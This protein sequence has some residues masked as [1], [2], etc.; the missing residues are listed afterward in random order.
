[1]NE[2]KEVQKHALFEKRVAVIKGQDGMNAGLYFKK[3]ESFVFASI[4]LGIIFHVSISIVECYGLWMNFTRSELSS[5]F[6]VSAWSSCDDPSMMK[7][8]RH[9]TVMDCRQVLGRTGYFRWECCQIRYKFE[10]SEPYRYELGS[11]KWSIDYIVLFLPIVAGGGFIVCW[12]CLTK[13]FGS[14]AFVS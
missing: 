8:A 11:T 7:A 14:R 3:M 4:V 5:A 2:T 13:Y 1:M 12:I 10:E 9:A 6:I